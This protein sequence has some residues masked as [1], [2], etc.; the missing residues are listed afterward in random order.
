MSPLCTDCCAT[1]D[2]A[3]MAANRSAVCTWHVSG[4]SLRAC[5]SACGHSSNPH[6]VPAR[7]L[8]RSYS[9][10]VRFNERQFGL[11]WS[12]KVP[13][14]PHSS[15]G[16]RFLVSRDRDTR[17]TIIC[18]YNC[19]M[20]P[21]MVRY[22]PWSRKT[23][24]TNSRRFFG[25]NRKC[26]FRVETHTYMTA[27]TWL[28]QPTCSQPSYMLTRP[29]SIDFTCE[30]QYNLMTHHRSQDTPLPHRL[31]PHEARAAAASSSLRCPARTGRSATS[32]AAACST[33]PA[34]E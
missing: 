9:R 22:G 29:Y 33:S 24:R 7:V 6:H 5:E 10:I 15:S 4:G 23:K 3:Y 31:A 13:C 26:C 21:F 25:E 16:G 34:G 17:H 11:T 18:G 27:I 8:Y 32:T 14:P 20:V 30:K 19:I 28:S 2:A 1:Q 12:K